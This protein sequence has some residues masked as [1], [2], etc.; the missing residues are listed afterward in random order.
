MAKLL[1]V[2]I[3]I[4]STSIFA[5][6]EKEFKRKIDSVP[7]LVKAC[8]FSTQQGIEGTELIA[9]FNWVECVKIKKGIKEKV[10]GGKRVKPNS[11]KCKYRYQKQ[12]LSFSQAI[13]LDIP[14]EENSTILLKKLAQDGIGY[15]ELLQRCQDAQES[16]ALLI[17]TRPKLIEKCQNEVIESCD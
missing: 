9:S 14:A 12:S 11:V 16:K 10:D 6:K 5:Q 17:G 15:I 13:S 4:L 3:L 2:S 1:I 7:Q 8:R